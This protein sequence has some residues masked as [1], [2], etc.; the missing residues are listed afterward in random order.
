MSTLMQSVQFVELIAQN[1]YGVCVAVPIKPDYYNP[2]APKTHPAWFP[3]SAI[4]IRGDT[5][6][7][8][9]TTLSQ[10]ER[11]AGIEIIRLP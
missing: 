1:A 11:Q 7:T 2:D 5:L 6:T 8:F 10:K 9:F 4:E 3:H